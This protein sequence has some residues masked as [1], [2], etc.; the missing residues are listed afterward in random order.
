MATLLDAGTAVLAERGYHAARVDDIVRAARTSHGT[1]YLYFANKEDLFRALAEDCARDMASLA[2]DL[3]PVAPGPEGVDELRSWVAR[4]FAVYRRHGAVIRAWMESQV[5]DR[6][7]I[8]LGRGAFREIAE[9]LVARIREAEPGHVPDPELAA[10]ALVA[11]VERVAFYTS[12]NV[13]LD[14]EEVCDGLAVLLHRGVFG[15][16]PAR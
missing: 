12:R 3:G 6:E 4:F 11:M 7:L 13:G 15:G 14:E 5:G 8:R 2:A 16:A 10:A 9:S 1:F